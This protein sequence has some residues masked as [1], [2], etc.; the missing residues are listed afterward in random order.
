MPI[1]IQSRCDHSPILS[2]VL[3]IAVVFQVASE[4]AGILQ[5]V[6]TLAS[7]LVQSGK[8]REWFVD[9]DPLIAD[10]KILLA[11]CLCAL[12]GILLVGIK[13]YEWA[14]HGSVG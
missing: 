11:D 4:R 12:L 9:A 6:E 5:G 1:G 14:A 3:I 13:G 10:V 7:E 8:C 2:G